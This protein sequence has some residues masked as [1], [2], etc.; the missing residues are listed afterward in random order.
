MRDIAACVGLVPS[1]IYHYFPAKEDLVLAV[2]ERS[3]DIFD[4]AL[5]VVL[6]SGDPPE[7]VLR[8]AFRV[9]ALQHMHFR[10]EAL[11]VD[12]PSGALPARARARISEWRREYR[13]QFQA[14]GATAVAD[15]GSR[16]QQ[17]VALRIRLVLGSGAML[18]R[19]YRPAGELDAGEIAD[20]FSAYAMNG[21]LPGMDAPPGG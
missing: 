14:V 17:M 18:S 2:L 1:A 20:E 5:A 10:K 13:G 16:E 7:D 6:R 21:L 3:F 12:T 19:W 8:D 9:H 4:S 11:L 15:R